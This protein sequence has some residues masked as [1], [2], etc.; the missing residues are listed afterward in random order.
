MRDEIVP[1]DVARDR[2]RWRRRA[3]ELE[4]ERNNLRSLLGLRSVSI[5]HPM[6]LEEALSKAYALGQLWMLHDKDG[7]EDMAAEI[8]ARMASLKQRFSTPA[9][10]WVRGPGDDHTT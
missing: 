2:D 3:A 7:R 10:H 4:N 5:D 6:T 8:A 1:E 9:T